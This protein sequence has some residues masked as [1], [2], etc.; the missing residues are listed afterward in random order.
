MP[1][2]KL[3]DFSFEKLKKRKRLIVAV[4]TVLTIAVILAVAALIYLII[5]GD[6][7]NITFLSPALVCI[8]F[9]LFFY[10]GLKKVNAELNKRSEA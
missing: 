2:E 10:I 5:I 7:N 8:F 1:K 4:L 9:I 3:E 6:L